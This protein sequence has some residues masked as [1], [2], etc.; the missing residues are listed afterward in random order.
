MTSLHE[1]Q[2]NKPRLDSD[3]PSRIRPLL[4]A[5]AKWTAIA[6]WFDLSDRLISAPLDRLFAAIP[7]L[8]WL[9]GYVNIVTH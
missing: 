9:D 4:L 5:T 7:S 2:R 6:V 1:A 8:A 3:K